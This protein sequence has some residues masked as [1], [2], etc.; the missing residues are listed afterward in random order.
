MLVSFIRYL[1]GFVVFRAT[2]KSPERFMNICAQRGINLW[3]ARPEG[4]G[5]GG[6]MSATDYKNILP[7]ARKAGVRTRVIQK[8]GFPFFA[9]R[10]KGRI[11]IP[12]G[13]A[14]GIIL[15]I[16]LSNFIWT[17]NI[18]GAIHVSERRL[19]DLLAESGVRLG[20]YKHA[21]DTDRAK[22]D[23]LLK[24]EELGWLSVNISGSHAEVEV[25]EKIDKPEIEDTSV[26]CNIKASEDG[27]ITKITAENGTARAKVGSGVAKGDLLVSG[28]SATKQD[29][30][31]YV[32]ARGEVYA[33]VF[34]KSEL[35]IPKSYSYF[36]LSENKSMRR[37][38]SFLG[39]SL[40]CSLSFRSFDRSV[41]TESDSFLSLNGVSLPL[42]LLTETEYALDGITV[43]ADRE[44]AEKQFRA[45]LLLGEVFGRGE[46]V[47]K[48]RTV[49][50]T[51][52]GDGYICTAD[53]VF[54]ENIAESV[55]F[56]AEE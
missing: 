48:E 52:G 21:I 53:Y 26:P 49:T 11:G 50:I 41:Y 44:R 46:G 19:K 27:V 20:A 38:L 54:N 25:R 37:R 51:D 4:G 30:V 56:T 45:S 47:V 16:V 6:R 1:K 9:A 36:S 17:I 3:N 33:D 29:E 34:S 28:V 14:A 8:R 31:R 42:G 43:S 35:K 18:S 22:R 32:R 7:V 10:Y 39:F 40:P 2:G 23:I 24:T 12:V 15:L 55:D 5:I 13:A